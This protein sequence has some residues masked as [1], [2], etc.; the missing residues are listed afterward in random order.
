M[1]SLAAFFLVQEFI[2][3]LKELKG[4]VLNI[5]SI[6]ANQTKKDFLAYA[7]SKSML[8]S[9][10]KS[11]AIELS[12]YGV[13]VNAV[14]PAAVETEMLKAGFKND[15]NLLNRLKKL[16]PANKVSKPTEIAKFSKNLVEFD[17]VFLTGSLITFDGGISSLLKDPS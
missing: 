3:E 1:N 10:T 16:H 14:L 17:D 4:A 8:N 12:Q 7:A 6:H 13:A 5:S 2:T 11:L 15:K 9:I